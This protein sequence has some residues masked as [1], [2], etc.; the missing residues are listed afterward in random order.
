MARFLK[1]L[2]VVGMS[3]V[4]LMQAPCTTY[5]GG[6]S[7]LPNVGGLIVNQISALTGGLI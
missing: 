6:V 5:N 4:Y 2:G 3:S 7:I 1:V